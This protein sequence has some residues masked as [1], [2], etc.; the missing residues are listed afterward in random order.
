M[1]DATKVPIS[2][3]AIAELEM[4]VRQG[5]EAK[6]NVLERRLLI[7]IDARIRLER[8]LSER[9]GEIARLREMAV[10]AGLIPSEDAESKPDAA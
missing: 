3:Q 10:Q 6:L 8:S 7:E 9:E 5:L 1:T 2:P 4:V